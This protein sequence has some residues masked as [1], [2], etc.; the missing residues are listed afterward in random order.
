STS[1]EWRRVNNKL[2]PALIASPQ[3]GVYRHP[4]GEVTLGATHTY[5]LVEEEIWDST[6]VHGP[7]E[8]E[9][10]PSAGETLSNLFEAQ[11]H[12]PE[13]HR[14]VMRYAMDS[15]PGTRA[16]IILRKAG[17]TH[18]DA[19]TIA[20]ALEDV[21]EAGV[22]E[23][24]A[25]GQLRLS[26]REQE[27]AWKADADGQGVSFIA[28]A[29]DSLYT[30]DNVYWAEPGQGTVMEEVLNSLIF[31]DDFENG[32]VS[33]WSSGKSGSSGSNQNAAGVDSLSFSDSIKYEEDVFPATLVA[34]DPESDYWY[35]KGMIGGHPT[36]GTVSVSIEVPTPVTGDSNGQLLV[37]LH[38]INDTPEV[39][40]HRVAVW[41]NGE[42][43]GQGI[44]H[45]AG[46]F[47]F[48]VNIPST[49]N[50]GA[51][52]VQ[53]VAHLDHAGPSYLYMDS[54]ELTYLRGHRAADDVLEIGIE[55]S[56]LVTVDGFTSDEI[57]V[58][59]TSDPEALK[60]IGSPQV[61]TGLAGDYRVSFEAEVGESY[62]LTGAS[63][64]KTPVSVAGR[65]PGGLADPGFQ[66]ELLVI[67]P[68][69]LESSA[70]E[71]VAQR[72]ASGVVARLALLEDI[73]DE[74][75]HGIANPH[76][77]KDMVSQILQNTFTP[78][79][80]V[81]L[82]G[83][84]TWDYRDLGGVGDC[85]V[86]TL[87]TATPYGLYASDG[88]LTDVDGDGM[89]EIPVGRVPVITETELDVYLGKLGAYESATGPWR[90]Q[91]LMLADDP[92]PDGGDFP[93]DSDILSTMIPQSFVATNV[94]LSDHSLMAARQ[95]TQ[96]K[97]YKGVWW[98][99][100]GGHGGLQTMTDEGLFVLADVEG[101]GNGEKL[102]VLS[103]LSCTIN[104]F[105]VPAQV[106]LGEA[107]TLEST[108]GAIAVW[109][110]TGMSSN[111]E[112]MGMN[113][114]LFEQLFD[115]VEPRLGD[116]VQATLNGA[117][118]GLEPEERFMLRVYN[119]IG[120]PSTVVR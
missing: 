83:K 51:N 41:I 81:V 68:H 49:L 115:G 105:T 74:F 35:W 9:V 94:Y 98:T 79:R 104:R 118:Q 102:S 5:R 16:K 36:L 65:V 26:H 23:W 72:S 100:F 84:G 37:R 14:Y 1:N 53:L 86:P 113:V 27:V 101:L 25:Q 10:A 75:N 55:E 103:A 62:L 4:D 30:L 11:A 24:I 38:G 54:L 48:A 96:G 99:N 66:A 20:D 46:G 77:I 92:D 111:F 60:V 88:L 52:E 67:A 21:D 70:T 18:L 87:F 91:I 106:S 71:Y 95:L 13:P 32:S 8:V 33:A 116:I 47:S 93:R 89:P 6:R 19:T 40:D 59:N 80:W 109:A 63:A 15:P 39:D 117:E 29:I 119:L 3:G 56:G 2:V 69:E 28:E 43:A 22:V 110:P 12:Q 44:G 76:A 73:Y 42:Y 85:L 61:R 120:D 45:G 34:T 58:I 107:L 78:P 97:L 112:A 64:M 50:D 7:F 57:T 17:L 82:L 31:T 114:S 108:G 90:E